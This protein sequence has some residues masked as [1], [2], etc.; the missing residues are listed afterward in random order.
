MS[1]RLTFT[2]LVNLAKLRDFPVMQKANE[3]VSRD[4]GGLATFCSEHSEEKD[5][6]TLLLKAKPF[7]DAINQIDE[8]TARMIVRSIADFAMILTFLV[9]L[10]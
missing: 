6:E 3:M 4:T 9:C 8:G 7:L 1:A 5:A 10:H 2:R